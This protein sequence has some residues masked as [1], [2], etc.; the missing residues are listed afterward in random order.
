M[1]TRIAKRIED[2]AVKFSNWLGVPSL[3]IFPLNKA[4]LKVAAIIKP[5]NNNHKLCIRCNISSISHDKIIDSANYQKS[6]KKLR[7]D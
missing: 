3:T 1:A 2:P 6:T 5:A 7:F 4:I